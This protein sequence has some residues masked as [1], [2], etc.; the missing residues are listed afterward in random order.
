MICQK[1]N[2]EMES[3]QG[4]VTAELDQGDFI[5]AEVLIFNCKKDDQTEIKMISKQEL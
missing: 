3:V 5:G 2:G 4:I 1:C